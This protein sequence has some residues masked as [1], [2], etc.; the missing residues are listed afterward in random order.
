MAW[1]KCAQESVH[2]TKRAFWLTDLAFKTKKKK[3]NHLFLLWGIPSITLPSQESLIWQYQHRRSKSSYRQ[4]RFLSF[5]R[6]PGVLEWIQWSWPVQCKK[7]VHNGTEKRQI[8]DSKTKEKHSEEEMTRKMKGSPHTQLLHVRKISLKRIKNCKYFCNVS[9][10]HTQ[11]VQVLQGCCVIVTGRLGGRVIALLEW[12]P[13]CEKI[14]INGL[15]HLQ[16]LI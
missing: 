8:R 10:L 2:E 7:T 15:L 11:L 6:F 13:Q 3:K 4:E 9:I 14:I 1:L 5:A 16:L 12:G